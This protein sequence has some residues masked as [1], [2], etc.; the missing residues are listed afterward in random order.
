[1]TSPLSDITPDPKGVMPNIAKAL[2]GDEKSPH[3]SKAD[4][5]TASHYARPDRE[6][7][8]S[9]RRV[10]C[11]VEDFHMRPSVHRLGRADDRQVALELLLDLITT[12]VYK[13][14]APLPDT[15]EQ[16]VAT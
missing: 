6:A 12:E 11:W 16:D 15:D 2:S 10:V 9:W 8:M 4:E 14:A 3:N 13:G 5:T 1:M 7:A